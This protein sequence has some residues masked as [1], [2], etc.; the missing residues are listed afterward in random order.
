M[1][2]RRTLVLAAVA[3]VVAAL[4]GSTNPGQSILTKLGFATA[5]DGACN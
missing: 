4:L 2:N 3:V 1:V 5:C